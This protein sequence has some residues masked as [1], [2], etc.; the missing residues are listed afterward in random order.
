MH[1][2]CAATAS[3][4]AHGSPH[5]LITMYLV[6]SHEPKVGLKTFFKK[7]NYFIAN[8][9]QGTKTQKDTLEKSAS[10]P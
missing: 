7:K 3:S 10:C 9:S 6:F 2:P 8:T 5:Q 4:S 1:S